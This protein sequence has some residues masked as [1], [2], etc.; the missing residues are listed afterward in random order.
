MATFIVFPAHLASE[1]FRLSEA[2]NMHTK[3][4]QLIADEKSNE[5]SKEKRRK[6]KRPTLNPT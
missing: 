5:K 2:L 1:H 6:P 4:S 3:K